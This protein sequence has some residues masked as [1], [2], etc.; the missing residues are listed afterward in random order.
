MCLIAVNLPSI[1]FLFTRGK[2]PDKVLESVRSLTSL[3]SFA[4]SLGAGSK[5][6]AGSAFSSK[7]N[8]FEM[9][10]SVTGSN[11]GK[12]FPERKVDPESSGYE[13]H[14]GRD[15]RETADLERGMA[16]E[17]VPPVPPLPRGSPGLRNW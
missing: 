2:V 12:A 14:V 7:K 10:H 16:E 6:A 13:I 15:D 8:C 3:R 5:K 11:P 4:S 17:D 9:P 1:W